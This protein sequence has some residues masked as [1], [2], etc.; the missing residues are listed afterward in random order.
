MPL[1]DELNLTVGRVAGEYNLGLRFRRFFLQ[2]Q[3][4]L[5][6]ILLIGSELLGFARGD[7]VLYPFQLDRCANVLCEAFYRH[8]Q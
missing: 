3:E 8:H 7:I 6:E 1:G 2:G 4:L 5:F